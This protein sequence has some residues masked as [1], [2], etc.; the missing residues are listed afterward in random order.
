VEAGGG[1]DLVRSLR[2]YLTHHG[3]WQPAA[4]ELG[5]HRHTLRHRMARV[6]QLLGTSLSSP[7]ARMNLWFALQSASADRPAAPHR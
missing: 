1:V 6:E 2:S 3:Q 7:Q 5:V 4:A